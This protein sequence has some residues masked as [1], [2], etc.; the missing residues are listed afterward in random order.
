LFNRVAQ[1]R[2]LSLCPWAELIATN[3]AT[4]TTKKTFEAINLTV[5]LSFY[6]K[7][8][9]D[10]DKLTFIL[11]LELVKVKDSWS[12]RDFSRLGK[13]KMSS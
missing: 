3:P 9:L 4:R 2:G 7:A 12:L 5:L 6:L 1:F 11:S 13:V 8:R 10:C